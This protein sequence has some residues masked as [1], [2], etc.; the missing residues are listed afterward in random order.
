MPPA[1]LPHRRDD[2]AQA[3]T[4]RRNGVLDPRRH[5]GVTIPTVTPAKISPFVPFITDTP[6]PWFVP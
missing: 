6:C 4:Q 1:P 5:F 3:L 2:G